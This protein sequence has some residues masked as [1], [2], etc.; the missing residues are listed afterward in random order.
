MLKEHWRN[1]YGLTEQRS[2]RKESGMIVLLHDKSHRGDE[3]L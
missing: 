3:F 2:L 1:E